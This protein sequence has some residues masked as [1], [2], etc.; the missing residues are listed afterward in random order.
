VRKTDEFWFS[1]WEDG[2]EETS[3]G[4]ASFSA[5][6]ELRSSR[7]HLSSKPVKAWRTLKQFVK[8][9]YE[10]LKQ[11]RDAP[12]AV[13]GGVAIG[14]FWGFTPLIGLK[15][16]LSILFAWIFRCSKISAAIAVSFHDI[17]TPIWPFFLRWEYDFGFWIL[18]S[19][20]HFPKRLS[21][22]DAHLNYWLHWNTLEILWPT[23]VGSLLFAVPFALISFWTVE[24]SLIQYER[25]RRGRIKPRA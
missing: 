8:R 7:D 24:Q 9:R 18:S 15:T 17:L 11:I 3:T 6:R 23:F 16:L 21:G 5:I 14:I 12:R 20:H 1:Y 4:L 2:C 22:D 13:A 25:R 19:P 10:Q